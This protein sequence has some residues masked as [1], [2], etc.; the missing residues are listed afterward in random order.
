MAEYMAIPHTII[1]PNTAFVFFTFSMKT[2]LLSFIILLN[3]VDEDDQANEGT[4]DK[5][6]CPV[7]NGNG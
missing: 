2:I 4:A 3:I 6:G 7:R 1:N 5:Q